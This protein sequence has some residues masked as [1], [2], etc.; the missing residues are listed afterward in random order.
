MADPESRFRLLTIVIP[1]YNEHST[2]IEVINTVSAL[3][4]PLEKE[5]VVV[6]DGSDDGTAERLRDHEGPVRI[7]TNPINEG[8]GSAVRVGLRNATG[9]IILLQDADLE[10]DPNEY[11][12]LLAPIL[13]GDSQ[14]VY[15][16]RFLLK[17]NR[18]PFT[19]RLANRF[20][21]GVANLLLGTSLTD[22]E[23]A[24]KVFTKE[25]ADGLELES[26]RFEVEPEITAKIIASGYKINEVPISY[27]PRTRFEGKKIRFVD[28]LKAL[29]TILKYGTRK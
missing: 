12:R 23:T 2:V 22:M 29:A 13:S 6:D 9:D 15:G 16:S 11:E 20:L 24:Y 7:F 28:G 1:V 5:I 21:T 26:N 10:T 25:V 8:K 19:R 4:L 27:S 17:E 18:V 14:A 3:K